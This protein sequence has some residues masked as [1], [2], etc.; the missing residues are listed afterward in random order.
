MRRDR[1]ARKREPKNR[2]A[3]LIEDH[4]FRQDVRAVRPKTGDIREELFG[5]RDMTPRLVKENFMDTEKEDVSSLLRELYIRY[6]REGN[7]GLV[8][9]YPPTAIG[10][11]YACCDAIAALCKSAG[12]AENVLGN[13]T[14]VFTTP[15]LKNLPEHDLR[16]AFKRHGLDY[17]STVLIVRSNTECLAKAWENKVFDRIPE[18]HAEFLDKSSCLTRVKSL[19]EQY[20]RDPEHKDEGRE[21][22]LMER[23]FRSAILR[24]ILRTAGEDAA[25]EKALAEAAK[26]AAKE[27]G[28]AIAE[29]V[30]EPDGGDESQDERQDDDRSYWKSPSETIAAH[31]EFSWVAEIYP[32][33][34]EKDY[35]VLLMSSMKLL[36]GHRCITESTSYLSEE[37][38]RDKIIFMDE[39]DSVKSDMKD[40]IRNGIVI[41]SP[42][43][44]RDRYIVKETDIIDLFKNVRSGLLEMDD[45]YSEDLK[46]ASRAAKERR[47]ELIGWAEEIR[48][49]YHTDL[50]YKYD[51][52][53]GSGSG[54][55]QSRA[56]FLYYCGEWQT[57]INGSDRTQGALFAS[58]D[59][60][61]RRMMIHSA[62]EDSTPHGDVS[63]RA[64]LNELDAFVAKAVSFFRL[65]AL[66]YM[67]RRNRKG[68][69]AFADDG[70]GH[71]VR[72]H[73]DDSLSYRESVN[74]ILDPLP[75]VPAQQMDVLFSMY[76]LDRREAH[77]EKE[78]SLNEA[79]HYFRYGCKWFSLENSSMHDARTKLMMVKI[80]DTPEQLLVSICRSALVIGMSATADS[81]SATE[82]FC[83][84]YVADSLPY[85]DK[86]GAY[87]DVRFHDILGENPD[88]AR[89]I[90]RWLR[91]KHSK[92]D[93]GS[94]TVEPPVVLENSY[95]K[96]DLDS[97]VLLG[98][99][100]SPDSGYR[101]LADNVTSL[102]KELVSRM[103]PDGES[104]ENYYRTRYVNIFR[105]ALKFA[106]NRDHQACLLIAQ[107]L[108][109]ESNAAM[110][111]E[112]I[113][114]ILGWICSY[115]SQAVK[116]WSDEDNITL[117]VL[118]GGSG[119]FES[120]KEKLFEDLK[121]GRR[122]LIMSAYGS[123][124]EGVNLQH[125]IC[126]RIEK[127]RDRY[128]VRLDHARNTSVKDIEETALLDITHLTADPNATGFTMN[129]Q[130]ANIMQAEECHERGILK[131]KQRWTLIRGGFLAVS[132][133][134]KKADHPFTNPLKSTR[135]PGLV[136]TSCAI[137]AIGRTNRASERPVSVQLYIDS[138]LLERL[139]LRYL[140]EKL[141]YLNPE[142]KALYEAAEG[143]RKTPLDEDETVARAEL[144][145]RRA[146][147]NHKRMLRSIDLKNRTV[148]WKGKMKIWSSARILALASPMLDEE[149]YR[150]HPFYRGYYI[151]APRKTSRYWYAEAGD[152]RDV[153]ISFDSRERLEER[154]R[155][156]APGEYVPGSIHE[157][158]AEA[159]RLETILRYRGMREH[160]RDPHLSG[161][162]SGISFAEEWEENEYI[163]SPVAFQEIYLGALGE[164]AG[165]FILRD[166][167]I[168]TE[169]I[170]DETKF[171]LMDAAVS[172]IPGA[173]VDFK[174]YRYSAS[175]DADIRAE[176]T[177]SNR[178]KIGQKAEM[179][180]A[181]G[182][183][184]IGAIM[185]GVRMQPRSETYQEKG[186]TVHY[187][188]GL[189]NEDGTRADG[190]IDFIRHALE[191]LKTE[192]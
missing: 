98:F 49:K 13:R 148:N 171:E 19:A 164:E 117:S 86:D 47:E 142:M 81:P 111:A 100:E 154:L 158:S 135:E 36:M 113:R 17:D 192:N 56:C 67:D 107:A 97:G 146:A 44:P 29:A 165:K 179:L 77:A 76:H 167:G 112:G 125:E 3:M 52:D 39:F 63:I 147:V 62:P 121:A 58:M 37:W 180:Q 73:I 12:S 95:S 30:D 151:R 134:G 188:P 127:N 7:A 185:P 93:A 28:K 45:H 128:L 110:D 53:A 33:V 65:Y 6:I 156:E 42:Y 1:K 138:R 163:L 136:A 11:T 34:H 10:K 132:R 92:Y 155:K 70:R 116:G 66:G 145:T 103:E 174:H 104:S 22:E 20:V 59:R 124:A 27:A 25:R 2:T 173:Y 26:K 55:S 126:E 160:F 54:G 87:H 159:A 90:Q 5:K 166:S 35:R 41:P 114:K 4:G 178:E 57:V 74:T 115:L 72:I 123:I 16:E 23:E 168:G 170:T 191:S 143:G 80:R 189:M 130:I 184:I 61:G 99:T 139:D 60:T 50:P 144:T 78:D 9:A 24:L 182:I 119:K 186:F 169:E 79:F 38:L 43:S 101:V 48:E 105:T 161:E 190:M 109:R 84:K 32:Q 88:A 89:D 140:R 85:T 102:I 153:W 91:E 8:L 75:G 15:L 40:F 83:L 149:K 46:D 31:P 69:Y 177:A 18:D 14:I 133:G 129:D 51:E 21:F 94:I 187:V 71:K 106:G 82:N 137:Q 108:P 96:A 120:A 162:L 68:R 122:K 172:G 157:V 141:P 183:F 64:M 150:S 175:A 181:R 131:A 176:S 152:Y 118:G